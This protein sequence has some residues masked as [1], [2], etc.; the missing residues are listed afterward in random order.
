MLLVGTFF[1]KSRFFLALQFL[2]SRVITPPQIWR[3]SYSPG[4]TSSSTYTI[5]LI[6]KPM[7]SFKFSKSTFWSEKKRFGKWARRPR[8]EI[9]VLLLWHWRKKCLIFQELSRSFYCRL[10]EYITGPKCLQICNQNSLLLTSLTKFYKICPSS[11]SSRSNATINKPETFS[12]KAKSQAKK[13]RWS[14]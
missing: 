13:T 6:P 11:C 2:K 9:W 10:K 8:V 14:H 7:T 4:C 3:T 1:L 12:L 5:L